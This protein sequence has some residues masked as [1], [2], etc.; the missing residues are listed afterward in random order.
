MRVTGGYAVVVDQKNR[1]RLHGPINTLFTISIVP[2]DR[3]L[4][5]SI[6]FHYS[7]LILTLSFLDDPLLL[8]LLMVHSLH[9][10][11]QHQ[12]VLLHF[13]NLP[14]ILPRLLL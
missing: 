11:L 14:L 8:I 3:H 13:E 6:Y 9:L 5:R 7:I 10:F 2:Q 12:N 1:F 4:H